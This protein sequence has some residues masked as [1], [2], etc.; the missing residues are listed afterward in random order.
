M[1]EASSLDASKLIKLCMSALAELMAIDLAEPFSVRV[2]WKGMGLA[3]YPKVIKHPMDLGT[4]REKLKGGKY[5]NTADFCADVRL[6]W[7]NARTY[8][9]EGSEI[10]DAANELE[11]MFEARFATVPRG[12]LRASDSLGKAK[13]ILK[14]LRKLPIADPFVEPVDH[15]GLKLDDYLEV[16]KHPM[17]LGTILRR[18]EGGGHYDSA[19]GVYRDVE[20]VWRNAMAYNIEGSVVYEAA[21]KLRA[22]ADKRFSELGDLRDRVCEVTA[23]MRQKLVADA[24]G[25]D[26]RE[27]FGVVYVVMHH[28]PTAIENPNAA[29]DENFEIDIDSLDHDAFVLVERYVRDCVAARK[30]GGPR[31]SGS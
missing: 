30:N 12:P 26:A 25:L 8:N 23:E 18:L 15:E 11:A 19:D 27:L 9:Q 3:D 7:C 22:H 21:R 10:Y 2:D 16:I 6:I 20:L 4:V 1:I 17:D 13:E 31:Q 28:C 29:D 24:G 5:A 14:Q